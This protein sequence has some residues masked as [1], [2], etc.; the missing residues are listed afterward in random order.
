[1]QEKGSQL[2]EGSVG[3]TVVVGD[4]HAQDALPAVRSLFHDAA[5]RSTP[6]VHPPA[7]QPLLE[8][9]VGYK[10]FVAS[11]R[12][13]CTMQ[14][15]QRRQQQG[16]EE[17][18]FS[19]VHAIL[20]CLGL[21]GGRVKFPY[22]SPRECVAE[23][24]ELHR[25]P[26][27]CDA[28]LQVLRGRSR[29][30]GKGHEHGQKREL[31]A[32][33]DGSPPRGG[34]GGSPAATRCRPLARR[35][36]LPRIRSADA[37]PQTVRRK[38]PHKI[39]RCF[40]LGPQAAAR[41]ACVSIGGSAARPLRKRGGKEKEVAK[42]NGQRITENRGFPFLLPIPF[43]DFPFSAVR[44][45]QTPALRPGWQRKTF[46]NSPRPIFRS[47]GPSGSGCRI[48]PTCRAHAS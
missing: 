12:A 37:A 43:F 1:M 46:E 2:V 22:F 19:F 27:C 36:P 44:K 18:G 4:L 9:G 31:L 48:Q 5:L 23:G 8:A 28:E 47:L 42:E 26:T 33:R 34:S 13:A 17:E 7:L 35:G 10:V 32:G 16:G 24:P 29:S 3:K 25:G 20:F 39:S 6:G 45:G 41:P 21:P 15:G 30:V 14:Q 40:M 38:A 11:W